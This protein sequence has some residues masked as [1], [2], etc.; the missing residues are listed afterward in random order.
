MSQKA[1]GLQREGAAITSSALEPV[2][3]ALLNVSESMAALDHEAVG[4]TLL[5]AMADTSSIQRI[6]VPPKATCLEL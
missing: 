2:L 3:T 6:K 4:R 1:Q 5:A